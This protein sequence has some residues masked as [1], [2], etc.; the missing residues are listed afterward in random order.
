MS[1]TPDRAPGAETVPMTEL[2][3]PEE[4]VGPAGR[5]KV[6]T[7]EVDQWL[8]QGYTSVTA[9]TPPAGGTSGEGE[10]TGG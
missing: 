1:D 10:G 4:L 5:I 2:T 8:A 7:Y 9:D 3:G 6:N